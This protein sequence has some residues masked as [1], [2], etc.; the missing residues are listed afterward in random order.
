MTDRYAGLEATVDLEH[1]RLTLHLPEEI[2][3][4]FEIDPPVK[5]HLIQGIDEIE[6]TLKHRDAISAF[7]ARHNVQ[8]PSLWP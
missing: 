8:L 6:L 2:S 4:H 1:Q 3:F 7:E 5:E